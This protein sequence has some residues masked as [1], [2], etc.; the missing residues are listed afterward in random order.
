MR[1]EIRHRTNYAY[2]PAVHRAAL[3]LRVFPTEF[4]GQLAEAWKVTVNGEEV[5]PL[6]RTG[7]GDR[8]ALWHAHQPVEA[9]EV[10]AEG[11]V[12]TTDC[13]GVV[14]GLHANPPPGIFLRGTPL[15]A[16][17]DAI[18]EIG[19][20]ARREG[21]LDTLHALSE[22]VIEAVEYRSGVTDA[23]TTAAEAVAIGAGV[24]Q[25]HTHIFIAAA[26]AI[27]VPARYVAGY[28]L[29]ENGLVESHET[30][31]WAEAL[32]QGLGWVGF[33]A[34]NRVCPT[35]RYVRLC[36]GLDARDAAPMR[37]AFL[38]LGDETLDATVAIAEATQ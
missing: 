8:I 1:L 23:T 9:I 25:D 20:G 38:G 21:A 26:R 14:R 29:S 22:G 19:E 2:D 3:R 10:L 27:G 5:A 7:Y 35:E 36:S 34:S 6:L 28:L 37:G 11:V 18:R 4:D 16:I 12:S 30:H 24:C 33:D 31:A 13:A 15:T 32:V 17:D